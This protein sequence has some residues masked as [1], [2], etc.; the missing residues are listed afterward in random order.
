MS[1]QCAPPSVVREDVAAVPGG[2]RAEPA[3]GGVGDP[4]VRPV[5]GD[6]VDRAVGQRPLPTRVQVGLAEVTAF[7]LTWIQ[8]SSVPA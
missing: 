6:L 4:P 8:P 3:V 2:G 7:G 5:D 1:F